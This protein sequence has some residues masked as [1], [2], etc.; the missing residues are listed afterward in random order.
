MTKRQLRATM[1]KKRNTLSRPYMMKC[2]EWI[3]RRLVALPV[4]RKAGTL[5]FYMPF[6]NE[7]DVIPAM[8]EAWRAGKRVLLPLVIPHDRS[9]KAMA[10]KSLGELVPGSFGILEP[11]DEM[12][13]EV[14]PEEIDMI[15]VPGVAFDRQGFRLGYGGGYYDRF[16]E[17]APCAV[18]IGV[19]YPEQL[20]ET[21]WPEEHDQKLH[22]LVT[23]HE[24]FTFS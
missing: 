14:R 15:I 10:V 4:F 18:R 7:A 1:L 12:E 22:M 20:V 17:R 21:V 5:L 3:C 6:R 2:S 23:S 19:A 8:E 11:P 24:T 13:R 9:M 16:L